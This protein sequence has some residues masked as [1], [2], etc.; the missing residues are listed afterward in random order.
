[1]SP[2]VLVAHAAVV[3]AFPMEK[4]SRKA[5]QSERTKAVLIAAARK[6]LADRGYA[7]LSAEE[8][9]AACNVTT[10]AVYHQFGSKRGLFMAVFESMEQELTARA[11][12]AAAIEAPPWEQ[13]SA[14]CMA[15]LDA[16]VEPGFRQVLL[17]DGRAVLGWEQW[18]AVMSRYGLGMTA[19]ALGGLM[20]AGLLRRLPLDALANLLFGALNEA[21][22]FIATASEPVRARS[23]TEAALRHLLGSLARLD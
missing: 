9:A 15:F 23:E 6:L 13:F 19:G 2:T 17:I 20:D 16:C 1:M 21:A 14:A 12:A 18:H 4:R 11:G 22:M 8:V 7:S 10:G 5:D 3:Q